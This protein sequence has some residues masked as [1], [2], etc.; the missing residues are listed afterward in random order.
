MRRT[1]YLPSRVGVLPLT[2]A[3]SP[4]V[5][6][7]VQYLLFWLSLIFWSL[8]YNVLSCTYIKQELL[9]DTVWCR[10][11][12]L[13]DVETQTESNDIVIKPDLSHLR[14]FVQRRDQVSPRWVLKTRDQADVW[15]LPDLR[16]RLEGYSLGLPR[17]VCSLDPSQLLILRTHAIVKKI[18]VP[19]EVFWTLTKLS[20]FAWCRPYITYMLFGPFLTHPPPLYTHSTPLGDP[21]P[22]VRTTLADPP[23]SKSF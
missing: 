10:C 17:Q 11:A 18:S 20:F 7:Q 9:L 5:C 4:Q 23:T 6:Q 12:W 22:C 3:Q 15:G 19:V 8:H 2:S 1:R 21:P 13:R 14:R 16:K